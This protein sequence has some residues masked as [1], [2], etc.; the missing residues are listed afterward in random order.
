MPAIKRPVKTELIRYAAISA[1][2]FVVFLLGKLVSGKVHFLKEK[3][4]DRKQQIE[5]AELLMEHTATLNPEELK[6]EREKLDRRLGMVLQMSSVLEELRQMGSN[7]GVNFVSVEPSGSEAADFITIRISMEGSYNGLGDF[8]GS[9]DDLQTALA[10]VRSLEIR[11]AEPGMPL[12]VS[13]EMDLYR[14]QGEGV[15]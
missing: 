5:Q 11:S 7:H 2:L 9:M 12:N 8:L 4:H 6:T 1:V 3:I 13:L 10:R 14:P 15:A